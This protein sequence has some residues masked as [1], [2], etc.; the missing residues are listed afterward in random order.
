[1][2]EMN[3]RKNRPMKKLLSLTFVMMLALSSQ[4]QVFV[5]EDEGAQRAGNS[6][7]INTIIPLHNV[8]YDQ[9]NDY[10]PLGSG[11]IALAGLGFGYL[12]VKKRKQD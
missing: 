12:L 3:N 9:E 7:D 4:A 8:E 1:M 11:V 10:V 2:K 6:S 5:L